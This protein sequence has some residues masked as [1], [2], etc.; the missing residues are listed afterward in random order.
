MRVYE[1]AKELNVS[2]KDM[3]EKIHGFGVEAANH[4]CALT[5]EQMV[6]VRAKLAEEGI[7]LSG[8]PAVE[9][10]EGPE[11]ESLSEPETVMPEAVPEEVAPKVI[12][13]DGPI[14]V[15]DFAAALG[16]KPNQLIAELMKLNVFASINAKLDFKVAQKLA[17]KHDMVLETP[18]KA[19]EPVPPPVPAAEVAVSPEGPEQEAGIETGDALMVSAEDIRAAVK[20][21]KEKKKKLKEAEAEP[22][23]YQVDAP[24]VVTFMGH[25]DHGK[26]SLL[27]RIRNTHVAA[28]EDGGITQHIGAY[29]VEYNERKITFL[30]TPGHAA[31][32]SMRARGANMTHIAVLV[33]AA[34]DGIM[35]QTREAMQH[36]LAADVCIIVAINKVDLP[37]A[38]PDRVKQQL[39]QEGLSP[40][41][42]GGEVGCCLVSAATGEGID[43]L[44]ARILLE[45]E[46]MELKATPNKAAEGFVIEAQM[47]PGRGPTASLL[48]SDGTLKV[49]DAVTCGSSWG[50]VKSLINDHSIIVR[51]A[52]PSTPVKC[53]GLT[54]VP[55]AGAKLEVHKND[56]DA[57]MVAESRQADKRMDNLAP[58]KISL[59]DWIGQ[60][61]ENKTKELSIVL[62]ADVKGSLEAISQALMGIKSDK[63]TV[64]I[65]LM[66]VGNISNNDV[67]L[68]SASNAI[69]VGFHVGL[70]NGV[71]K[72]AKHE[73]VDIRLYSI[74]YELLDQVREAMSGMLD[75]EVREQ[76]VGHAK[77][78]QVFTLGKRNRVAG[79]V[80]TDGR[81]SSKS[82]ARV[83]HDG[84]VVFQGRLSSLKRF[85]NDAAEVRE[86]QECGLRIGDF[87]DYSE[88]DIIEFFQV[89]RIAQDL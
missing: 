57:R 87:D 21:R 79:C 73:G 20:R 47:E 33:V 1:L 64:N 16:L 76:V 2:S 4:M 51:T 6:V 81:I 68:A 7:T 40:E 53:L 17:E 58:K 14:I 88:G 62:K 27:D 89:E 82:N 31:F 75:P 63:V 10:G 3:L 44:L 54:S 12:V 78:L 36:A 55:E 28:G 71:Q 77:V 23:I 67:L 43:D 5:A 69:I 13:A 61:A 74:I 37:N 30:D 22:D 46:M 65:V 60:T 72:T 39:Q 86:T 29:T 19:Q 24:P 38:N 8:S 42:W 26:T 59:D 41:D 45:A 9:S 66:G 18:K 83:L 32:T 15:K 52:G 56:K 48:I 34:D 25:V 80:C 85:Q 35:P 50:R 11:E 84:S 49:G 70:E